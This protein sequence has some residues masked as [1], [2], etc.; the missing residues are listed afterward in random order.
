MNRRQFLRQMMTCGAA[1]TMPRFMWGAPSP[2][3]P[4]NIILILIDDLGWRDVGC[5]GSTLYETP[6]IDR[7]AAEG[8]R[9]TD[10]YAAC[11]VCSPT[12]ASIMTGKYPAR[13]PLTN[14]I[15]GRRT[16]EGS[17][18]L[19]ADY[20]LYMPNEEVTIA[21]VLKSAGYATCHVGKWHMGGEKPYL[22]E[23]QGFDV[24]IAGTGSGMPRSF[25]WPRWKGN[26]PI[27]GNFD[28]EYLSDRLS[29]EACGFIETHKDEPFF[30]Y[31][32]HYAVHIPIEGKEDKIARYKSKIETSPPPQGQ[33]NNP[34]YAAMVES[35]DDSVGRV[36][37]TL[38]R[39]KI[40]D[41]T[42]IFFSADNGGLAT[43]E[44]PRT[45]ATTNAPLRAGKGYLY[46]GG[47]REPWIVKWP[48]VV[49]PGSIC[50]VPVV[51]VDFFPTIC[52]MAGLDPSSVKTKGPIDGVSIVPS[53][54][55]PSASLNREAIY[56][57]YPHYANQGG[58]PGAAIRV[59]DFKLIEGYEF[60]EME[61]YNLRDDIGET[62]NLA[63]RLPNKT[64]QL[65]R[66]LRRW[67]R[68]VNANMP[69]P[70]PDYNPGGKP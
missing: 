26:P 21:E 49:K 7:L 19:P 29:Q 23:S 22:P 11:P 27:E 2:A 59:G 66:M 39:L 18:I 30:L 6:N 3:H 10:A 4:P 48:G 47:I 14:F 15:A 67:R 13:I 63:D 69:I 50:S 38:R 24:N 32:S 42:V 45:P 56:W 5:F 54:K 8:M 40:D 55:N 44:G 58:R 31:L 51:S 68:T 16:R 57:H 36:L 28:G 52:E 9:F 37:E 33:Q 64:Q 35:V 1:M 12:R 62:T 60:G 46:E 25:F 17:P 53:L 41:R 34:Y 43:P 61:L 20:L 70:N 65:H